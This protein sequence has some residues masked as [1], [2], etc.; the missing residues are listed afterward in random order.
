M[1]LIKEHAK[2]FR[3]LNFDEFVKSLRIVMQP[4]HDSPNG[5]FG[6]EGWHH[7]H[8]RH[9]VGFFLQPASNL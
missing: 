9:D 8:D 1:I 6:S 7:R 2:L 4:G 5:V 3:S